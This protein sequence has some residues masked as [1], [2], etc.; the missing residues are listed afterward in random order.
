MA[1]NAA[2]SIREG[3]RLAIRERKAAGVLFAANLAL[4]AIAALPI[5]KG[6]LEF[7][8]F[9]SVARQLAGGFLPDWFVDFSFNRPGALG[10]YADMVGGLGLLAIPINAILAG[11]V[12]GRFQNNGEPFSLAG[13]FRGCC[14]YAWPF[15]R[16]MFIG[17][18]FY[19]LVFRVVGVWL[20]KFV[21]NRT[22]NT[23]DDRVFFW[24]HLGVTILALL[25]LTLVNLVM[26]FAQVRLVL[27][28][29]S[30]AL[31]AIVSS[32]GFTLRRLP[33]AFLVYA[34]PTVAGLIVPLLYRLL[35]LWSSTNESLASSGIGSSVGALTLAALFFGQQA[36]M[37]VR[38]WFRVATWA[39]EW[40]Y[41]DN[42]RVQT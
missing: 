2:S 29:G 22:F 19:W 3:F 4:A 37:F 36:L 5:Y 18:V 40:T 21:E 9:T 30:T 7:T 33:A 8:G 11:G 25:G 39:S 16:L 38:Y 1:I 27:V 14:R 13:F 42:S 24:P 17:L 20:G 34:A 31:E 26:D 10:R 15:L 23:L 28:E 12:F 6:I 32:L 41:Y 35:F